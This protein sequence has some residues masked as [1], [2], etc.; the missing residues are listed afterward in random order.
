MSLTR[1]KLLDYDFRF[2]FWLGYSCVHD[3]G[4]KTSRMQFVV[5][6]PRSHYYII[7]S[8]LR[9]KYTLQICH[10]LMFQ[11]R[12]ATRIYTGRALSVAEDGDDRKRIARHIAAL[13]ATKRMWQR[14]WK[15]QCSVYKCH[16]TPKYKRHLFKKKKKLKLDTLTCSHYGVGFDDW[17]SDS[18]LLFFRR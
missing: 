14:Q 10:F 16:D 1:E 4:K 13:N 11:I 5:S 9:H 2:P 12:V 6:S 18:F 15:P 7:G 3:N 17:F 8:K